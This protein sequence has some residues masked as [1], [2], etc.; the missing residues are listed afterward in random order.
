MRLYI[1]LENVL[2]YVVC[3]ILSLLTRDIFYAV[4]TRHIRSK[5]LRGVNT[6]YETRGVTIHE[7]QKMYA[8]LTRDMN[9]AASVR[10][11]E[12]NYAVLTRELRSV[13]TRYVLPGVNTLYIPTNTLLTV[14]TRYEIRVFTLN[15]IRGVKHENL[16]RKIYFVLTRNMI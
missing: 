9:F 4:L 15:E 11:S 10:Y 14:N 1:V 12:M 13:N 8:V 2:N 5:N 6:R 7:L 16:Y 3:V